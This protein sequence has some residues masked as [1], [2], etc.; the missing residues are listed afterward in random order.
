MLCDS[1]FFDSLVGI[2]LK[3]YRRFVKELSAPAL[4]VDNCKGLECR[5]KKG[6]RKRRIVLELLKIDPK[7][8]YC[9]RPL[10]ENSSTL[11][12]VIPKSKGGK[13]SRKNFALACSTCNGYKGNLPVEEFLKLLAS[14]KGIAL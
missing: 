14:R 3:K 11:D 12:H 10:D 5:N 2:E 9:K 8:S 4:V 1:Q 13:D 6:R 7:C